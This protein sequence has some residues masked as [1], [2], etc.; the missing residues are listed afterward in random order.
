M[1]C[2][3]VTG[4]EFSLF[5]IPVKKI[6]EVSQTF[7]NK[8]VMVSALKMVYALKMVNAPWS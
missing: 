8:A 6:L 2:Q 3:L 7:N 5:T 4:R 1:M